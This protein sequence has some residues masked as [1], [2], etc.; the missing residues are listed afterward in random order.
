M[1]GVQGCSTASTTSVAAVDGTDLLWSSVDAAALEDATARTILT[2]TS[3]EPMSA[4]T[5][6]E[7]C[8]ASKPTVYR[9][10]DDLRELDLLVEQTEPDP[11]GGHHRTVYATN[12]ERITVELRDGEVHLSVDRR[13]DIADRFTRLIEGI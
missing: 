10:L 9:R 2:Q 1:D 3:L 12:M 4:T 6:S 7:R 5:L 11:E 13:P 8:D